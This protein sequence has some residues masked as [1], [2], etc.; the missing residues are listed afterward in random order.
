MF[1][2]F[3][4]HLFVELPQSWSASSVITLC[5]QVVPDFGSPS[6]PIEIPWP[7]CSQ[8]PVYFMCRHV[9]MPLISRMRVEILSY[10]F[11]LFRPVGC[12]TKS[13]F[14]EYRRVQLTFLLDKRGA[15]LF[16]QSPF[17]SDDP[18]YSFGPGGKRGQH[19]WLR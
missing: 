5:V 16:Y 14:A 17:V 1:S 18:V 8:S 15:D 7:D 2:L 6:E 10:I 19:G 4:H 12:I 3:S 13:P 11:L 9:N